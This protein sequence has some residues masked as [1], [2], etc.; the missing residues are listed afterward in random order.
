[1]KKQKLTRAEIETLLGTKGSTKSPDDPAT[2]DEVERIGR[3]LAGAL[4][5]FRVELARTR[6]TAADLLD[7]AVGDIITTDQRV[8]RPLAVEVDGH[9]AFHV[10]PGLHEDRRAVQIESG[11]E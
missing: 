10:R 3:A 11:Q 6:V 8:D 2:A 5:E 9:I 4:V 1:M 7:L